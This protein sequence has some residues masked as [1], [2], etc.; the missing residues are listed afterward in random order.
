MVITCVICTCVQKSFRC[1]NRPH[2]VSYRCREDSFSAFHKVPTFVASHILTRLA[3]RCSPIAFRHVRKSTCSTLAG[4][5]QSHPTDSHATRHDDAALRL[6]AKQSLQL[7]QQ[8]EKLSFLKSWLF[9]VIIGS[10][11]QDTTGKR[12]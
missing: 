10:T 5:T 8:T 3:I 6:D 12:S 9:V 7:S 11:D 2:R 4:L 1:R